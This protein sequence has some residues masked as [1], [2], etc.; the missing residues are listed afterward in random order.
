VDIS[1][2]DN[3]SKRITHPKRLLGSEA[4]S[5]A[6]QVIRAGDVLV[7]TTRP[8]LN[9]V[10]RVSPE[11]DNEIASTGFCVL[12]PN[13]NLH[14]QYLYWYVQAT[15]FV[16]S[17]SALVQGAMYPAVTDKQ[18]RAQTIPLPTLAEQQRI[19]AAIEARLCEV[20]RARAAV[21]AQ[22]DAANALMAAH[23]RAVFEGDEA[24]GWSRVALLSVCNRI[25]DG[26]HQPPKFQS[27]GIPFLFVRNIVSGRMDFNVEKYISE[28][29]YGE[30]TRR[31]KPERGDVLFSAVGSF[32][33]AVVVDTDRPFSFQRHIAHIK[34]DH[35]QLD[36]RY[37]AAYLNAP[38]GR[39]QSEQAALGVA[40]RTVTLKS[41]SAF[42]IPLPPLDR[43]IELANDV[44]QYSSIRDTANSKLQH[45]LDLIDRLPAAI[46]R[47]AFAGEL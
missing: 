17:L 38:E 45:Q 14:S 12:R 5:R 31:V 4:P 39:Q 18:V 42:K 3:V 9:A 23:L 27:D 13:E 30:L 28:A 1:S 37:L 20:E 24:Q 21:Q 36:S 19:A 16:D 10:A 47:Q 6:R 7:A 40:Q 22:R 32:G 26:T 35:A 46:L 44:Y 43:Q 11:L 29:T 33:V 41:L 25:T 34:P 8:N 15:Q 2:I